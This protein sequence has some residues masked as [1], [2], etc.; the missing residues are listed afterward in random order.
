ME[1]KL[2]IE[3]L[4]EYS[5]TYSE[6][7]LD[8][9]YSKNDV[10][11]GDDILQLSNV[12]Q[13]NLFVIYHLLK[14]WQKEVNQLK[15]PYFDF[16]NK[17]VKKALK[18]FANTLSRHI[19]VSR[20]NLSQLFEAGVYETLL[21]T[22]SPYDFY[23]NYISDWERDRIATK[24]LRTFSRYVKINHD[25]LESFVSEL[26]K[27]DEKDLDKENALRI[28]NK[29]FS[30]TDQIPDDIDPLVSDFS[31]IASLDV[32]VI[33]GEKEREA[34]SKPAPSIKKELEDKESKPII[35][36]QMP[37]KDDQT[38][39]ADLHKSKKIESIKTHLT[40]NQKFMFVNQ[41]FDGS[42]DDF[43]QV[44]DFLDNCQNQAEAMD[45]INSNYLKKGSWNKDSNEV[46][47]FIEV[48]AT[49]YA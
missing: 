32:N 31:S 1:S 26:E 43:N 48:I 13:V 8:K 41:L 21:L 7:V 38:I 47:E 44:V 4:R 9:F 19:A 6:K 34:E 36:D 15:S 30:D 27:T 28:L 24:D 5:K 37:S 45:F 49:K 2:N 22:L 33:Y 17:E 39:L 10:A 46:K 29:V 25:L 20:D 16:K 42:V 23:C 18:E 12:K 11:T 35:N 14:N 3:A 40:I